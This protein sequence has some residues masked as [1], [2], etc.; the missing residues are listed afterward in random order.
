MVPK[1]ATL[2]KPWMLAMLNISLGVLIH[3]DTA[4][5][6]IKFHI[7]I[8]AIPVASDLLI[9]CETRKFVIPFFCDSGIITDHFRMFSPALNGS[10][11]T[12]IGRSNFKSSSPQP[13][14]DNS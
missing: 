10:N 5:T 14:I 3:E 4:S 7:G 2:N 13:M 11:L 12:F 6:P 9:S 8:F 1:L